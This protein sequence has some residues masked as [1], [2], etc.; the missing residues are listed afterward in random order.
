LWLQYKVTQLSPTTKIKKKDMGHCMTKS[1]PL[2]YVLPQHSTCVCVHPLPTL[3]CTLPSLALSIHEDV[4]EFYCHPCYSVLNLTKFS[5]G[6][7][8]YFLTSWFYIYAFWSCLYSG[9]P[10]LCFSGKYSMSM[11]SVKFPHCNTF[12]SLVFK[13][14]AS[15]RNLTCGIQC[16]Q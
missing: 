3:F 11:M 5:C 16:T 14:T 4:K 10:I 2:L 7:S 12:F 15:Q 9:E 13:S 6:V 1:F 8:K